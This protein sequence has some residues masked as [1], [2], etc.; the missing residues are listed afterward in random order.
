MRVGK[1]EKKKQGG[2]CFGVCASRQGGNSNMQK[3]G[4]LRNESRHGGTHVERQRRERAVI[5]EENRIREVATWATSGG[6]RVKPP[7]IGKRGVGGRAAGL[8]AEIPTFMWAGTRRGEKRT[9]R[10]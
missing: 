8:V 2:F 1:R 4:F 7:A 10:T 9:S 5:R 6:G 3:G